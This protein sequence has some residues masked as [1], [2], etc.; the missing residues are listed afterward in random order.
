[1]SPTLLYTVPHHASFGVPI[2]LYIFFTGLSAG[3]FLL[4]TLSY[5]FGMDRYRALSLP[6]IVTAFVMLAV[7]PIFLLVHVGQPLRVWHLFFFLNPRSPITWGS[8]LLVL[9]PVLCLLYGYATVQGDVRAARGLGLAGIP[10]AISVHA[11]TGFILSFCACRPLW[12]TALMP[13]L[14]LVSAVASGTALMILLSAALECTRARR[15]ALGVETKRTID[16]LAVILAWVLVVDIVLT[17]CE[18]LTGLAAGGHKA[19]AVRLLLDGPFRLAFLG[20]EMVLGKFVPLAVLAVP[21]FRTAGAVLAASA[22][23]VAGILLM[24]LD[25]VVAG[26]YIPLL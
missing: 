25:I 14:F 4:S 9:Y 8:F 18:V 15:I 2:A 16:S 3:S 1:V 22:L 20:G 23:V 26:E 11:Y 24:R 21:R 5:G 17:A 6:G 13:V 10:L 12:H 19:E 7:A